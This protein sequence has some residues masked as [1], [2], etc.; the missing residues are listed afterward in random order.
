MYLFVCA[1]YI[2]GYM[3]HHILIKV[4]TQLVEVGSTHRPDGSELRLDS[5]SCAVSVTISDGLTAFITNI[6]AFTFQKCKVLI[7]S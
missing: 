1:L 4:R 7:S 2:S 5:K 3:C 6:K